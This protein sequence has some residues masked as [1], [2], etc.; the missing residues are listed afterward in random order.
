LNAPDGI[1][2]SN[3]AVLPVQDG[4][5]DAYASGITQLILDISAYFAP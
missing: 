1:T 3:M 4:R 2:A 5:I